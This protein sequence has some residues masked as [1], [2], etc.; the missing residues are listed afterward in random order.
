L[1]LT[2]VIRASDCL[3]VFFFF[4]MHLRKLA[5]PRHICI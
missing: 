1:T 3:E 5:T 4:L 2:L